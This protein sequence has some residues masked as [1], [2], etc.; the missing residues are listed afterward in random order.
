MTA[1]LLLWADDGGPAGPRLNPPKNETNSLLP[2]AAHHTE[3]DV[4]IQ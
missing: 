1:L 3:N 4:D 2:A